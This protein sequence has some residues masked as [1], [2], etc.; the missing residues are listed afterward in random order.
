MSKLLVMSTFGYVK[1]SNFLILFVHGGVMYEAMEGE[2]VTRIRDLN[3]QC[4]SNAVW[5][6]AAHNSPPVFDTVEAQIFRQEKH[7]IPRPNENR[8]QNADNATHLRKNR[9]KS[10]CDF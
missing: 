10:L 7:K 5:A 2:I 4:L 1:M 6:Y 9:E 8:P 3:A